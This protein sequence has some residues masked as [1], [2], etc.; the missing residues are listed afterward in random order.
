MGTPTCMASD[1]IVEITADISWEISVFAN[2]TRAKYVQVYVYVYVY[3]HV[4]I[5]AY[6]CMY[7]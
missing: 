6:V 4:Y 2:C 7:A 1:S 5:Y 3:V